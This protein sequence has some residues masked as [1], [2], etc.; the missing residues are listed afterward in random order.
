[1]ENNTP[2]TPEENLKE[3][4]IIGIRFKEAGK[5][6]YFAPAGLTFKV[7][8]GAIV[9]TSR[10]VEYGVVVIPNKTVTSDKLVLPL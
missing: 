9:E 8:D 1:M 2:M 3:Y 5:V 6:Y 10:G 4:E 7:G